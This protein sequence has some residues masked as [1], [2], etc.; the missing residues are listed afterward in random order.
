MK[1]K[2]EIEQIEFLFN[3]KFGKSKVARQFFI[4]QSPYVPST[5]I[6]KM[7]AIYASY[8]GIRM[9]QWWPTEDQAWEDLMNG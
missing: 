1:S 9:T 6:I 2:E 7:Y 4:K 3:I 5:E 8:P